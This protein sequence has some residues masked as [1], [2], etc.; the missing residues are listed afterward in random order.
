M[1]KHSLLEV[2]RKATCKLS[3]ARSRHDGTPSSPEPSA[4]GAVAFGIPRGAPAFGIERGAPWDYCFRYNHFVAAPFYL[5]TAAAINLGNTNSCIAGYDLAPGSTYY[6]FCIPS[7]VAVT[8]NG[9]LSG[10]AAM[11]HAALSPGTAISGF[12]RL[13]GGP[14]GTEREMELVPYK[15]TERLGWASIQVETGQDGR[16]KEFSPADLAGILI[17]ELKHKAEAHLGREVAHAVIAVPIHPTYTAR[18]ALVAAGRFEYGFLGVK[19]IDQQISVAA[20]Y[21]HHTKQGGGK[22]VLVFRLGG[23]TS[24]ATIF[25]FI[26]GTTRYIAARSDLFLGGKIV[27]YMWDIRQDKKALLRL[28]V[29]CEHAKKALSDQEETLVQVDSLVDGV[30]FS[31][32]LTRAK[33][34]ELNQDLFDR[35]MGLLEEVVMGTGKPRVDSRKDMVDEI[36]LVG[37]SAR[38]PKVRQ[39]VKEYFHGREP[40]SRQGV[41]PEEAVVLGT[42]ILSRPEAARYIE[43]CFDH[44]I[45]RVGWLVKDYFHGR[46][47]TQPRGRRWALGALRSFPGLGPMRKPWNDGRV[48]VWSLYV[49]SLK[50]FQHTVATRKLR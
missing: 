34:E 18:R 44:S 39:L 36:V 10:A 47:P 46:G 4:A 23:R 50:A 43:E 49:S 38:I 13:A 11:D 15:I 25:K 17:S 6:Q 21:Q 12:M 30:S 8:D 3:S 32:P 2:Q 16:A 27:D 31:A 42:A 19:V 48:V 9:T 26:N 37:G 1:E 22:A 5:G 20:A 33:L 24:D 45:P 41:E 14:C 28:R 35:A 29:A 40:N 7:W